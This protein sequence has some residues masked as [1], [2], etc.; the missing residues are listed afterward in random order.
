MLVFAL[1]FI[2]L[3]S[4]EELPNIQYCVSISTKTIREECYRTKIYEVVPSSKIYRIQFLGEFGMDYRIVIIT[5]DNEPYYASRLT[6]IDSTPVR[7]QTK[8]ENTPCSPS[9][10]YCNGDLIYPNQ[11]TCEFPLCPNPTNV[12]TYCYPKRCPD[13]ST[14]VANQNCQYPSC[15]N[16]PTTTTIINY[17][18]TWIWVTTLCIIAVV[19]FSF[20]IFLV[21]LKRYRQRQALEGLNEDPQGTNVPGGSNYFMRTNNIA[22]THPVYLYQ[23]NSSS[24]M[25]NGPVP[26]GYVPV[27]Q[28]YVQPGTVLSDETYAR[29][30]QT[31]FDQGY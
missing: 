6:E 11:V 17:R 14:V 21:I 29:E 16:T 20:V 1:F 13:G 19:L 18:S 23:P 7:F 27:I 10:K 4:G 28:T 5:H 15:P 12:P 30:L 2:A 24:V 3:I 9:Y 31:R 25:T 22:S 26:T 8:F